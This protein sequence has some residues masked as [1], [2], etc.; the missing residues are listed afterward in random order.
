MLFLVNNHIL[1]SVNSKRVLSIKINSGEYFQMFFVSLD[2]G[3]HTV[4]Q[5][6]AKF[7]QLCWSLC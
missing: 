6:F 4:P 7:L 1:S 5:L 2:N 3:Y